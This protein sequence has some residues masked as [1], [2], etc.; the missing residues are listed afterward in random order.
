MAK[1]DRNV[2]NP[3]PPHCNLNFASDL[4]AFRMEQAE[5]DRNNWLGRGDHVAE[6]EG[7]EPD[8]LH[9]ILGG[10]IVHEG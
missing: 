8:E 2:V 5:M 9:F 1:K 3:L 10:L 4:E 6:H 7:S